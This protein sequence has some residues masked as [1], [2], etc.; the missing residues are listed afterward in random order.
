[1]S[2]I[3]KIVPRSLWQSAETA[4]TFHGAPVDHED[5][6]IHFSTA[7]Q[8]AET[9]ARHFKDQ[10]DLLLVAVRGEDL[11]AALRYEPSRGGDL[12]PHLYGPL[13]LAVVLRVDPHAA[14]PRRCADRSGRALMVSWYGAGR[15]LLF[16]LDPELAHRLSIV[17]LR[18]GL[19]P[20]CRVPQDPRLTVEAAGMRF[21]HPIGM[22]AGYDKNAE[23]PD[24]LLRI[25]F[26]FAEI[27]S[28]TPE[29]QA[30]NPK[31]RI[32]RLPAER[33][34]INRLGFNNEGHQ[35]ALSRLRRC[36]RRP[37]RHIGVNVGAN[38]DA[39]DRVADYVAGIETFYDVADYF[40]VNISSPNTPGLRDLHGR[41]NLAELMEAVCAARDRQVSGGKPKRALFLKIAPDLS[42]REMDHIAEEV[43]LHPLDGLIVS[44]TTLSRSAVQGDR[45]GE[46]GGLS[47]LPLF[48]RSTI[49]LA[50]MRRRVGPEIAL[51][52][53]GGVD[54]GQRAL[55]KIR[56]GA[57]LVQL[58]TGLVY[59][60]PGL[61][62]RLLR[63][64]SE[65][66]GQ[67][68]VTSVADLRDTETA[69]WADRPIPE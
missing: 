4:G 34:V 52:G 33:A 23:V 60:G 25:G 57:D 68:G 62:P 56:A 43:A 8:L 55:T 38:K 32:F 12:F 2:T 28:V 63:E 18:S 22:A 59:E 5:G 47:G 17:A 30:G 9:A 11:G 29:P 46:A 61:V 7:A 40:T 24:A 27:G 14:R 15:H 13:P 45:A 51:I 10:D 67:A 64:L 35:A 1:M 6:F 50:K 37:G 58:Y 31:P 53:L 65:L 42:E 26:A 21:D 16:K 69:L 39:E 66:V 49:V 41:D 44:N 48:E 3:Y 36:R 19:A 54:S 20:A